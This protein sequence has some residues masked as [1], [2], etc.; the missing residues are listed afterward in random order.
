MVVEKM[1]SLTPAEADVIEVLMADVPGTDRDRVSLAQVP[2]STYQAIQR[3][4]FI[5]GWLRQRYIPDPAMLGIANVRLTLVQP[6]SEYRVGVICA[7]QNS[8]GTVLL[9]ASPDSVLSVAL[10]STDALGLEPDSPPDARG[11]SPNRIRR[12]WSV[13]ADPRHDAVPVYFDFEGAWARWVGRERPVS[14]PRTFSRQHG[15][16]AGATAR[17][18]SAGELHAVRQLLVRPFLSDQVA[19]P[20]FR[21]SLSTLPRRQRRLLNNGGVSRRILPDFVHIPPLRGKRVNRVVF[22]TGVVRSHREPANLLSDLVAKASVA[23]FLFAY[24]PHRILLAALSPAPPEVSAGRP[25]VLGVLADY[26]QE[27]EVVREP[28]ETFF[29]IVDH[30]YE[31]LLDALRTEDASPSVHQAPSP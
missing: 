10:E 20:R 13:V 28:F 26:L 1:R 12:Q 27:I 4:A 17:I 8:P 29:P 18:F 31:R 5:E 3:R 15:S 30:R 24:D 16:S 2:R 19:S 14:Y 6:F 7:L 9:W 11:G 21:L 22:I 25:S 23:P